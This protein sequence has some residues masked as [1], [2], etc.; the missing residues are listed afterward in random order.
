MG[1]NTVQHS[2]IEHCRV[3]WSLKA[4]GS[5]R[6]GG[7]DFIR[8]A[9]ERCLP[10]SRGLAASRRRFA[11]T[12]LIAGAALFATPHAHAA[13]YV[14]NTL[15]DNT[16]DDAFCTLRE[17]I[18]AANN[19]AA[20][21]NCGTGSAAG[22]TVTFSVS[23]TITLGSQLPAIVSGQG[24]LTINGGGNITVSGNNSVRVI[25]VNSGA[26][27]T[28][29]NLT[30]ANGRADDG[31]GAYN[32]GV[33]TVTN[34]TFS[35]NSATGGGG[36]IYNLEG[37]LT[38]TNSTFSGNSAASGGGISNEQI[39]VGGMSV[40]TFSGNS[41]V[42]E[43]GIF[44]AGTA[45]IA[46]ST[47]SGNSAT[48]NGGGIYNFGD[49]VTITNSTFSG[50]SA[51]NGGGA[52]FNP[53]A[54]T[55]KNTIVANS[56]SGGNCASAVTDGGNNL[57][58]GNT[59]GFT[60]NAKINTNPNLGALTGSP[61]YFPLNTGSPAIDAGSNAICAAAP[62][63]NNSQNGVTRPT[64]GDGNGTALCDIGAYEAPGGAAD[65]GDSGDG[66]GP[67]LEV[68]INGSNSSEV[69][70]S[71]TARSAAV[72]LEIVVNEIQGKELFFVLNAPALGIY[73]SYLNAKNQWVP[74]PTNWAAIQPFRLAPPNGR[75]SLFGTQTLPAGTYEL[76]LGFDYPVNGHLDYSA[77]GIS[78]QFV[79]RTAS[80]ARRGS[81]L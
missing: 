31:G 33:L 28:L 12:V 50:N 80:V 75:H 61:A 3:S 65:G 49:T 58:S 79:Q 46:N 34:S 8:R 19:A 6:R 67:S 23:G 38:V 63:N 40:S 25:Q 57:D 72:Q 45:T 62:V 74:V 22:D 70:I 35:G 73:W 26:D 41:P 10:R 30:I 64:D 27:L 20:N 2:V 29:Q 1:T 15:A 71:E 32:N 9:V 76:Y 37:T 21:A 11:L 60:V 55:L 39:L 52:I 78:G 14:V 77:G 5:R 13:S 44:S 51:T 56:P 36:G 81:P 53:S 17:A 47:F 54:V 68:F 69:F 4:G 48:N 7:L 59:C 66:G 24:A 16:T 18:S 43:G 42:G